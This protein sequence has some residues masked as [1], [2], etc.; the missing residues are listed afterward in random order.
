MSRQKHKKINRQAESSILWC[1]GSFAWDE[2]DWIWFKRGWGEC[3]TKCSLCNIVTLLLSGALS[4]ASP[5]SLPFIADK[6]F[7]SNTTY[8]L[9]WDFNTFYFLLHCHH[10]LPISVAPKLIFGKGG[11]TAPF[12]TYLVN[13]FQHIVPVVLINLCLIAFPKSTEIMFRAEMFHRNSDSMNKSNFDTISHPLL[14][15]PAFPKI[16]KK[17]NNLENN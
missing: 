16:R 9:L 10:L 8:R 14:P 7:D 17:K 12:P 5:K 13:V 6:E 2:K 1:Q 3:Q 11:K 15:P 4:L